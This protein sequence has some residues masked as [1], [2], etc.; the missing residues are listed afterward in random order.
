[1]GQSKYAKASIA[2]VVGYYICLI[3]LNM[4]LALYA[5]YA[6]GLVLQYNWQASGSDIVIVRTIGM[7]LLGISPPPLTIL[8]NR[9]LYRLFLKR[10]RFPRGTVLI[11]ICLLIAV[12]ALTICCIFYYG[13][14]EKVAGVGIHEYAKLFSAFINSFHAALQ[15]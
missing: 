9:I 6:V 15:Q 2:R 8:L 10:R 11:T 4:L 7:V 14:A 12:Q 5:L 1:M 3:V 13:L